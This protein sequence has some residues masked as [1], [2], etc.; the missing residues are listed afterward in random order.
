MTSSSDRSNAAMPAVQIEHLI[1]LD[2]PDELTFMQPQPVDPLNIGQRR[3][4]R[5]RRQA[6]GM[7][8]AR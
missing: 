3:I 1:R 6:C 4:F 7:R 5:S 8:P 2:T